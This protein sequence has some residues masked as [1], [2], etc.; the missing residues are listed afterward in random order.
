MPFGYIG[1]NQTKQKVKNSGVLSSFGVSH[2]E[3]QG[4]SGFVDAFPSQYGGSII[5]DVFFNDASNPRPTSAPPTLHQQNLGRE[6]TNVDGGLSGLNLNGFSL[7]DEEIRRKRRMN[8]RLPPPSSWDTAAFQARQQQQASDGD[9]WSN[10]SALQNKSFL[11]KRCSNPFFKLPINPKMINKT[12]PRK[13]Y[14]KIC[15]PLYA[16]I[17]LKGFSM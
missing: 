3:K 7:N 11:E 4:H 1:Q 10:P 9:A 2:L 8:P 17:F 12:M 14:E 16:E 6:G 5:R 13:E 15:V